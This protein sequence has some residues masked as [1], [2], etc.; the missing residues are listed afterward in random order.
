MPIIEEQVGT[1]L[2]TFLEPTLVSDE[3]HYLDIQQRYKM[4]LVVKTRMLIDTFRVRLIPGRTITVTFYPL[5]SSGSSISSTEARV[6]GHVLGRLDAIPCLSGISFG[7][8]RD[9]YLTVSYWAGH[10]ITL[11]YNVMLGV[12]LL[13]RELARQLIVQS[14]R[15]M[16]DDYPH[17]SYV[18]SMAEMGV[19]RSFEQREG[20]SFFG[21]SPT[22]KFVE[23][24]LAV[25]QVK[26]SQG[27]R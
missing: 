5:S 9:D 22:A 8:Y 3:E 14:G 11:P 24:I 25:Y 20:Q 12:A 4:G 16:D 6:V 18:R 13:T 19:S 10:W 23:S 17:F 27:F 7:Q 15:V 21:D 26:R 1:Y 2:G